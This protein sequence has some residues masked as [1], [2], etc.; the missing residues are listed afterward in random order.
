MSFSS[1]DYEPGQASEPAR[2]DGSAIYFDGMSN[3]RRLVT[4]AF[5][6]QLEL[7]EPS[8]T[9]TRWP[10]AEVR[11]VDSPA[12]TLRLTCLA[13]PALSRLEIRDAAAA[14]E[15]A[16]R[17]TRLDENSPGRRGVA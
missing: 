17:C 10:Y 5:E 11:R 13:A 4:L 8:E 3:R 1:T 12:G 15:L 16:A 6:D 14:A 7:H 9:I 2:P